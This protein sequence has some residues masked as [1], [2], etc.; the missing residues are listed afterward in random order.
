ME[1]GGGFRVRIRAIRVPPAADRPH[2]I[3][4][5]LCLFTPDD[6]RAVC[7]DNAHPVAVGSGPARRRSAARDHLHKGAAVAPYAYRDAATLLE[8]FW[9]EVEKWLRE[10][11][12]E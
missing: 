10:R 9:D 3:D 7:F 11:G 6:E 5:S 2:G 1:V 12:I 8:D 4:Y